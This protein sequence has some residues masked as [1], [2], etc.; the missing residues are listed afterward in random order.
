M[1][2]AEIIEVAAHIVAAAAVVAAITP[3]PKDDG[4]VA[5]LR[6]ALD[7]AAMNWGHARNRK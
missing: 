7:F 5:L 6:K 3:T 1:P 2:I 4:I